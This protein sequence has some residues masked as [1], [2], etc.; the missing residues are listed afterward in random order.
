MKTPDL[1]KE[2]S[3]KELSLPDFLKSYN[4]D[5]PSGFPHASLPFL[6]EFKKTFPALF[7]SKEKGEEMWSLDR[8]RKK[9]MDWRPQR[10]KSLPH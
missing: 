1:D 4:K 9:F 3:E 8:H 6:K 2:R 10:I 5:L 7:K